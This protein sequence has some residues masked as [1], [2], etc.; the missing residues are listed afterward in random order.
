MNILMSRIKYAIG[1]EIRVAG[2]ST[3]SEFWVRILDRHY[4]PSKRKFSYV[5]MPVKVTD[6]GS[7]LRLPTELRI[8]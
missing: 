6:K 7:E 4:N 3:G 1:Q 2:K 8:G 5:T